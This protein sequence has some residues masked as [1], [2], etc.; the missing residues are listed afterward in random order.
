MEHLAQHGFLEGVLTEL[1]KE[2]Y[3][4]DRYNQIIPNI[5]TIIRDFRIKKDEDAVVSGF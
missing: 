3:P 5:E 2:K 1:R 4:E